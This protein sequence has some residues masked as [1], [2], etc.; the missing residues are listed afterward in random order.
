M[1]EAPSPARS[2]NR[3]ATEAALLTATKTLLSEQ[4]FQALGINAVARQAKCDKQ[5]IYRYFGGLDGLIDAMGAH[6]GALISERLD[7]NPPQTHITSYKDLMQHLA[8]AYLRFLRSDELV[9]KIIAWE[10]SAPT[11][12]VQRLSSARSVSLMRWIQARRGPLT[13]P[14]GIDAPAMNAL[15]IGAIQQMVLAGSATGAFMGLPL[16]SDADWQRIEITVS[17]LINRI[18]G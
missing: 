15:V 8:L 9:Q 1:T 2:R 10:F 14:E 17:D 3:D 16:R 7:A 4:G 18:Y 11:E 6:L 12:T 13:P 5:L